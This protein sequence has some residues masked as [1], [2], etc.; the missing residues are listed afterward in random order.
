MYIKILG[1][2]TFICLQK[3]IFDI[4]LENIVIDTLLK[5]AD[6]FFCGTNVRILNVLV[7]N[8]L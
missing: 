7:V 5:N 2:L 3:Q 8:L 4:F 6:T 1:T